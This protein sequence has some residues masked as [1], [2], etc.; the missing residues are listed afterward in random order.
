M[1][2]VFEELDDVSIERMVV[3]E[4]EDHHAGEVVGYRCQDCGEADETLNQI[5]HDEEENCPLVGE[6]G[7]QH[8]DTL[9]RPMDTGETPEFLPENPIWAV[10]AGETDP[11]DGVYNGTVVAFKC[12]CGNADDDFFEIVHDEGC[13]LADDDCDLGRTDMDL[14]EAQMARADGGEPEA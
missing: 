6:H 12:A 5:W 13:A 10:T 4:C 2:V 7:R 3:S 9:E 1:K 8:Y 14:F 11:A